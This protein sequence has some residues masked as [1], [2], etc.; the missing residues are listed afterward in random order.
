MNTPNPLVPSGSLLEQHKT[1]G[2]SNLLIAVFTILAIHVVL[3]G[4]LLIQGCKRDNRTETTKLENTNFPAVD[5]NATFFTNYPAVETNPP[6]VA[7]PPGTA[8]NPPPT[9]IAGVP[10]GPGTI[11]GAVELTGAAKEYKVVKGDTFSKIAKAHHITVSA[12]VKANPGVDS[13]HLKIGQVLQVPAPTPAKPAAG[14]PAGTLP[15]EAA[16]MGTTEAGA[17]LLYSVKAKDTLTKIATAHG[18]TVKALSQANQLKTDRLQVGQKLKIPP[19]AA[20]SPTTAAP[21]PAATRAPAYPPPTGAPP[22]GATP[23]GASR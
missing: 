18:V 14:S 15:P 9:G 23:G 8:T 1:K 17:S 11:P 13:A 2:K 20:A 10:P 3:F 21:S 22:I 5:T 7:P 12:M 4:G 16:A 19:K 6:G